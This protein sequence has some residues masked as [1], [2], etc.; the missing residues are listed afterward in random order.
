MRITS[1]KMFWL[2]VSLPRDLRLWL[3]KY[4]APDS[5]TAFAKG[6]PAT[7]ENHMMIDAVSK[8]IKLIRRYR[9]HSKDSYKRPTAYVHRHW[10]DH[11]S[12]YCR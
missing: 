11:I 10:A 3:G 9:G 5:E 2:M 4:P 6:I 1:E 8:H 12:L 7:V